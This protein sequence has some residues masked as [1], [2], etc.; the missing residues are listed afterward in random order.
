MS[1]EF[2]PAALLDR[3]RIAIPAISATAPGSGFAEIANSNP[4]ED[5]RAWSD[6]LCRRLHA[7]VARETSAGLG[8]WDRAWALV[9]A[10]SCALLD[11]LAGWE[12]HGTQERR[13]AATKAARRVHQAWRQAAEEWQAR[14]HTESSQ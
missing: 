10:P 13:Q 12:E 14:A 4:P 6:D 8:A 3:L 9:E 2:N 7:A 5:R 11:A 1:A